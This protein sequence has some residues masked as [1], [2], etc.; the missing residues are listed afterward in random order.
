VNEHI[1]IA[2]HLI[3]NYTLCA[4]AIVL[5]DKPLSVVI[6]LAIGSIGC[7]LFFAWRERRQPINPSF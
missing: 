1:S 7:H 4:I 5:L 6:G 2:I 3:I